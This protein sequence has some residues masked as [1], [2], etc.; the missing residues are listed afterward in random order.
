LSLTAFARPLPAH[1]S[2]STAQAATARDSGA[3]LPKVAASAAREQTYALYLPANY[4]AAKRWP[5]VYVFS[6]DA[7]GEV[8]ASL[9]ES[10]AEEFGYI[11]AASNNSKNGPW[12]P[13]G[14][15]A[16]AVWNDTHDRLSIDDQRVYFAGFSGGARVASRLAQSC[17]CAQAVFLAGASFPNDAPPTI[18]DTFGVFL[19]AGFLDFNYP[20]LVALDAQL[21]K[22]GTPHFLRRFDGGHQWPPAEIWREALAFAELLAMKNKHREPDDALATAQLTNFF[23]TAEKFEQDGDLYY[24]WQYLR[25][26]SEAFAGLT[27]IANVRSRIAALEKNPAIP[28]GQKR[29]KAEITEQ[30][31]LEDA[32]YKV[33]GDIRSPNADGNEVVVETREEVERLRDRAAHEK[34]VQHRRVLERARRGIFAYFIESGE[35][36]MDSSDPRLARIYFELAAAARPESPWPQVSLARCD[37]KMGRK[38]EALRD[39]QR[40][41]A[42]GLIGGDFATLRFDSPEFAAIT[43]DA[44]FQ[45]LAAAASA[46][47]PAQ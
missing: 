20:E 35:P 31:A 6:P 18:R 11:I 33:F 37:L 21:D 1:Q 13:E 23:A 26:T 12:K 30:R 34:N 14:Q 2:P 8:P 17:K 46:K 43:G 28:A 7:R 32:V 4:S 42:A 29:E 16:E 41:V 44:E 19:I 24:S 9:A 22:L 10:A 27:D 40:A 5:I 47:T 25:A 36:L 39:L 45:K 38:T 15:A 3:V